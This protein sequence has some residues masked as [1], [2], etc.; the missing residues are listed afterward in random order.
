MKS[1]PHRL[2]SSVPSEDW[3]DGSWTVD[4]VCGVNFDDGEEMVNCDEC[5]VWVHTRCSRFVKGEKSFACDKCKNK[6]CRTDSEETEVAQLLVELPTKTIRMKNNDP[7]PLNNHPP[8]CRPDR[9][10]VERPYEERVHVQ[11][12]PG[13]DPALFHGLSPVFSTQLWKCT[14]Y[15]PKKLNL[16]YKEFPCWD[17]QQDVDAKIDEVSENMADKGAGVLYS[18]S[19]E[20]VVTAPV[21]A[22]VGMRVQMDET[23]SEKKLSKEK[24]W[25]SG[26]A[27]D[28]G[29]QSAMRKERS[30]R[31]PIVLESGKNREEIGV[32]KDGIGKKKSMAVDG[33]HDIKKNKV[34][35]LKSAVSPPTNDSQLELYGDHNFNVLKADIQNIKLGHVKDV[36]EED[37]SDVCLAVGR[38]IQ[39]PKEN[40][41]SNEDISEALSSEM[42]GHNYP[43]NNRFMGKAIH[44]ALDPV[45]CSAKDVTVSPS[46]LDQDDA[47]S[48]PVKEEDVASD[49]ADSNEG[50]NSEQPVIS[51][52]RSESLVETV[53][54]AIPQ[55]K[56]NEILEKP[57][58]YL[59]D[60]DARNENCKGILKGHSADV[61]FDDTKDSA[62]HVV[63]YIS[64]CSKANDA[65]TS[66]PQPVVRMALEVD[67]VMEAVSDSCSN[68]AD[69]I[70][71]NNLPVKQVLEESECSVDKL[72]ISSESQHGPKVAEET[73]TS[74]DPVL[75]PPA[76]PS[77]SK[78]FCVGKSSPRSSTIAISKSSSSDKCRTAN[79]K[80]SNPVGNQANLK[81]NATSKKDKATSGLVRNEGKH[82]LV[83]TTLKEHP[84]SPIDPALRE[85]H[86]NKTY[87]S[88][89][90][91]HSSLDAKDHARY[92]SSK[93]SSVDSH[94]LQS[95]IHEPTGSFQTQGASHVQNKNM[96]SD[97]QPR[98]EKVVLSNFQPLFKASHSS[99]GHPPASTNSSAGLS[100]EE[101]ALLLHQ[102]L[103]SS[104]RVPRV[105]RVRHAGSLPQLSSPSAT[106][107]LIKRS[108]SGGKEQHLFSR[109]KSKDVRSSHEAR[110]EA[111]VI[112]R[113]PSSPDSAKTG[114]ALV[115]AESSNGSLHS[116]QKNVLHTSIATAN[117]VPSSADANERK[118]SSSRYSPRNNSDDDNGSEGPAH[119][120]LP[121]LIAEIMSKGRR[122][123]YEELCNAV[124]PHWH[125][126]RK[127]NGERYAYSSHS[128]A[129]LDC[130][131]NRIEWAQLVDRGPKTNPSRKRRKIDIEPPNTES[132][133]NGYEED[134]ALKDGEG[135]SLESN[136]EEFPKGKRKARKRRRS[137]LR[138][139]GIKDIR[140]ERKAEVLSDD[141]SSS[142]SDSTEDSMYSEDE[143]DGGGRSAA[144]SKASGTSA[145]TATVF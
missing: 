144:R 36:F 86:R 64:Q 40:L 75:S 20:T 1:R 105:P 115:Q 66:S 4:C 39:K 139:R 102:E 124:L 45:S 49:K 77:Q 97:L 109:R 126:L 17:E 81:Y 34:H 18:L 110:N 31:G 32:S 114:D 6:S 123:T 38:N 55:V 63:S 88:S 92:A 78:L 87:P 10:W 7:C 140:K 128:Q 108:G 84:K 104:P 96:A 129:V 70:S 117:S 19:K 103:N 71:C 23:R 16:H 27:N 54:S 136:R 113:V 28:R 5:G 2:P 111:R 14:G 82:Q 120:T 101:L 138:G 142:F 122:M 15:V 67:K 21:A 3:V 69:E 48:S 56:D 47:G 12:I 91:K 134:I 137:A 57:D 89:I 26:D 94:P 50:A 46:F 13:G 58:A 83:C 112:N 65:A 37:A 106:S 135:K 11:G 60:R 93:A 85:S 119:R 143:T 52:Q 68:K 61:K 33:E 98:G 59:I 130:L 22:L 145:E 43:A 118:L 80:I 125:N 24:K 62:Q 116:A 73:S 76:P 95:S 8:P 132:E 99:S 51:L 42:S 90:S 107:M 29:M 127:H 100:D 9:L 79:S 53:A 133:D 131:R 41:A 25:E 141:D 74:R 72:K 44:G 121:G 30:L 35:A